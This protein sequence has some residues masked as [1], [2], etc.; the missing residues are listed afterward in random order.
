MHLPAVEAT[1]SK[2]SPVYTVILGLAAWRTFMLLRCDQECNICYFLALVCSVMISLEPWIDKVVFVF[3]RPCYQQ[4][5]TVLFT[6]YIAST[7]RMRKRWSKASF[8]LALRAS[9]AADGRAGQ[10]AHRGGRDGCSR[11]THRLDWARSASCVNRDRHKACWPSCL[12][13]RGVPQTLQLAYPAAPLILIARCRY[14]WPIVGQLTTSKSEAEAVS[15]TGW[16]V[17]KVCTQIWQHY[18]VYTSIISET[19]A[20][21]RRSS[22][23]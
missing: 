23:I 22:F 20:Y 14:E 12:G 13:L 3:D 15:L 5:N 19:K 7:P 9:D 18:S 4:V 6:I 1:M 11:A 2:R 17:C 10:H 21:L 8:T 16:S